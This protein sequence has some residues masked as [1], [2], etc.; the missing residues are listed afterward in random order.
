MSKI[1]ADCLLLIFNELQDDK[2]HLHSCLLVN[3]AWCRIVVRILWKYPWSCYYGYMKS[4][5]RLFNTIISFLTPSSKQYLL[6]NGIELPL[7]TTN[8]SNPSFNYI[9]FCRDFPED[10]K[11][12]Y[13]ARMMLG[14]DEVKENILKEEIY[15]LYVIKCEDIKKLIWNSSLHLSQF[16]GALTCFSRLIYL[17]VDAKFVNSIALHEM[18]QLC[19][20]I[21]KIIIR[22]AAQD[23]SGLIELIDVQ[24]NLKSVSILSKN[25]KAI[26]E[27]LNKALTGKANTI[28]EFILSPV[29]CIPPSIIKSLINLK[30]LSFHNCDEFEDFKEYSKILEFLPNLWYFHVKDIPFFKDLAKLIENSK[31]N[32]EIFSFYTGF[33]HNENT[34][35]LIKAISRNCP[36]IKELTT[37][38]GS[39]DL[40]YLKELLVNCN[41]LEKIEFFS[42][43]LDKVE[44]IGDE[45]CDILAEY[46]PKTLHKIMLSDNWMFSINGLKRFLESW[47]GRRPLSFSIDY[48]H[49][50]EFFTYGHMEI[51]IK[52][53]NEG[54]LK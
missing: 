54:V 31:G 24:R 51:L 33:C 47:R 48:H 9:S 8:F 10:E 21:E 41:Y 28:I 30:K 7:A 22:N 38:L 37:Y 45:I 26:S 1:N 40:N 27:A 46:S 3:R 14:K 53:K 52:Y 44:Y 34:G 36:K 17:D 6:D 18:A 23:N 16:P 15:K 32:I 19:K 42:L 35:L 5:R 29:N 13:F 39:E 50:R 12:S 43:E 2:R 25:M 20:D 49:N 11:I 4:D